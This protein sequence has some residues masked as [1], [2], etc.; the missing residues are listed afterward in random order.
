MEK[1]LEAVLSERNNYPEDIPEYKELSK[2]MNRILDQETYYQKK[3]KALYS[4]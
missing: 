1:Q 2:Q 3:L 4:K